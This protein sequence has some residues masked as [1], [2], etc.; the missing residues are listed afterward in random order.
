MLN[1]EDLNKKL[2]HAGFDISEVSQTIDE[3]NALQM[4]ST[5]ELI[6]FA[7]KNDVD[8]LFYSYQY[9]DDDSLMVT[10]EITSKLRFDNDMVSILEDKLN[11]YNNLVCSLYNSKN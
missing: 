11:A 3:A 2:V 6:R 4:Q 7:G 5:D 10:D 1:K 8:T 9:I